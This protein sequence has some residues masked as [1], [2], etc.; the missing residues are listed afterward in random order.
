MKRSLKL[1]CLAAFATA[2]APQ[3]GLAAAPAAAAAEA[4]APEPV[5]VQGM[6]IAN[7]DAI[8]LNSRAFQSAQQQRA[9]IFKSQIDAANARSQ[10]INAEL[11]T[12]V[13][14]FNLDKQ[15]P[16]VSQEALQQQA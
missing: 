14:Q 11:K 8:V 7:I 1:T 3:T 4:P 10:A 9:L 12:M 16:G 6:A 15:A 5:M 2:I 13:D